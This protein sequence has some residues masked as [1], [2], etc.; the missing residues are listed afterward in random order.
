[1]T[2]A[3]TGRGCRPLALR[4]LLMLLLSD[5]AALETCLAFRVLA[6]C[7]VCGG[8]GGRGATD[9][10]RSSH[11]CSSMSCDTVARSDEHSRFEVGKTMCCPNNHDMLLVGSKRKAV[12]YYCRRIRHGEVQHALSQSP[13]RRSECVYCC[14]SVGPVICTCG[15]WLMQVCNERLDDRKQ[16]LCDA[17]ASI[18]VSV[19]HRQALST[20][21]VAPVLL[22]LLAHHIGSVH[23]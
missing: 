1:M 2:A 14:G 23:Y 18:S 12:T 5:R 20:I 3:L 7:D 19:I 11:S 16:Y 6:L 8:A 13:A 22:I 15:C 17:F 9:T 4:R 21:V 10:L